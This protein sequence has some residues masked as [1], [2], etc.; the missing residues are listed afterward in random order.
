MSALHDAGKQM[1]HKTHHGPA[2]GNA[3]NH[4]VVPQNLGHASDLS[5]ALVQMPKI[6]LLRL[7]IH[8]ITHHWR[9]VNHVTYDY[10]AVGQRLV[11]CLQIA[12][13]VD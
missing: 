10:L 12:G 11:A 4:L 5:Q 1:R 9:Q 8:C 6:T 7:C 13:P 2:V 3:F